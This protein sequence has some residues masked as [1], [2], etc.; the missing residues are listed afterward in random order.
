M[1]RLSIR[2]RLAFAFAATLLFVLAVAA[3]FVYLRVDDVLTGAIDD[4]TET[5]ALQL[6]AF[7]SGEGDANSALPGPADREDG[8]SQILTVEG[9]VIASSLAPETG[10]ALDPA[11]LRTAASGGLVTDERPIESVDGE[12]RIYALGLDTPTGERVVVAGASTDDRDEALAGILGAFAIG[13][14]LAVLLASGLGYLLAARALAPVEAIRRRAG[15]ITLD[16]SG[17]RLPL[18]A[19]DDEIRRLCETLNTMLDRIEAS[20]ERE[21]V[22]VADAAHELRTPL[23][24]LRTELELAERPGREPSE[25]RAALRSAAEETLRLSR[26][27]EDLLVIARSDEG[28][29]TIKRER[30]PVG[31]LLEK[32]RGRFATRAIQ[33][34]REVVVESTKGLEA[35]LDPLRIEQALGNLTDNALRHGDAEIRLSA[36]AEDGTVVFE[37]ADQGSGF[38]ADF[39]QDAFERFSRADEGRTE[40][41]TGLGLAIV[42]A[43]TFAHGGE[44]TIESRRDRGATVRLTIPRE[45]RST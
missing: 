18:P 4:R 35:D 26:L 23:A 21:R 3:L 29:L 32:V 39:E 44:A 6:A 1:K 2:A 13:A 34:G 42:Q 25:M 20:L 12:S 27:A 11:Q 41:G 14:P 5:Q 17:E 36:D 45:M 9:E 19:A 8:F 16:R 43:I 28:R 22:F 40:G 7:A 24:I 10:A 30:T 15:E 33:A 31:P 38:P 37:V